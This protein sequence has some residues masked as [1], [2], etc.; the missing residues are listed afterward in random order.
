MLTLSWRTTWRLAAAC[1]LMPA[2]VNAQSASAPPAGAR[3][4][5]VN[6][7]PCYSGE[8]FLASH[9]DTASLI[10]LGFSH[11]EFR[12]RSVGT[13]KYGAV[14]RTDADLS[15]LPACV[16][17]VMYDEVVALSRE[18]SKASEM[19]SAEDW[20]EALRQARAPGEETGPTIIRK[21]Y[22]TPDGR[23]IPIERISCVREW[24]PRY[25]ASRRGVSGFDREDISSK[26][27]FI[28]SPSDQY[29]FH[30]KE[31]VGWSDPDITGMFHVTPVEKGV[32]H[33]PENVGTRDPDVTGTY[34]I[35]PVEKGRFHKKENVGKSDPGTC[36]NFQ[37]TPY[38]TLKDCG[39]GST[40]W[41]KKP[42]GIGSFG[43]GPSGYRSP[44]VGY[45]S[46]PVTY[47]SQYR[48]SIR[49]QGSRR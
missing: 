14:W 16:S 38:S 25:A 47:P 1:A 18:A 12:G 3:V 24:Q 36:G 13:V 10:P 5:T 4:Q 26:G 43:F 9:A 39:I 8:L 34:I 6:S 28:T 40:N 46:F 45:H 23:Y 19:V 7:A 33:K 48:P 15:S 11:F 31:D 20:H 32:F 22:V 49:V 44:G 42:S 17:G 30:R 29:P 35:H 21:Y 2:L 41:Y 37:I 27:T